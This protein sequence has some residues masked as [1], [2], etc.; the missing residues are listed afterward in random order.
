MIISLAAF[1][2]MTTFFVW[3]VE[4]AL[5]SPQRLVPA[6]RAGGVPGAIATALPDITTQEIPEQ[7]RADAKAKIA[8][9]VTP[10]YLDQKTQLLVETTTQF[11]K[12]GSPQPTLDLSDF[13]ALL[14]ANG[15]E[16]GTDIEK[17]FSKPIQLNDKG[18]ISQLPQ[19]YSKFKL[20]KYIGAVLFVLLLAAE[21]FL[22]EKGKKL[23]R[24]G[25]IFL[26]AGIWYLVSYVLLI[27]APNQI[28]IRLKDAVKDQPAVSDIANAFA[29]S[30][31]NLFG[32]YILQ[33]AVVC[34]TLAAILYIVRF[35]LKHVYKINNH[36]LAGHDAGAV[37]QPLGSPSDAKTDT[38]NAAHVPQIPLPKTPPASSAT[39][40]AP[41]DPT[42][43]S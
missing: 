5:L 18:Q 4:H 2:L 32:S 15:V 13:P 37:G 27:V 1:C 24:I 29:K 8:Q 16:T 43:A 38:H 3:V 10:E 25:R 7:D 11:I 33:F 41:K 21:W 22:A 40:T 36:A 6:L 30:I 34:L 31:Q 17:E 42:N 35:A 9:V 39:D 26:H 20:L 12:Q 23:Q 19:V 28:S 14:K